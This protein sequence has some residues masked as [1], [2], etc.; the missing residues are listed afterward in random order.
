MTRDGLLRRSCHGSVSESDT[1]DPDPI[2]GNSNVVEYEGWTSHNDYNAFIANVWQ[3]NLPTKF[4]LNRMIRELYPL[5]PV[6]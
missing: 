4:L 5:F 6:P 2:L 1:A 3:R